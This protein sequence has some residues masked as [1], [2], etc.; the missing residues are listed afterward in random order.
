MPIR[1][2]FDLPTAVVLQLLKLMA[3]TDDNIDPNTL[4][5]FTD[6]GDSIFKQALNG[7]ELAWMQ[8]PP[9]LIEHDMGFAYSYPY[10]S[11]ALRLF[12]RLRRVHGTRFREDERIVSP[13]Q[14]IHK[15][16][17]E[18]GR[19][20]YSAWTNQLYFSA[21]DNTD[22]RVNGRQYFFE[23]PAFLIQHERIASIDE[24]AQASPDDDGLAP[25]N[26]AE[27]S[28]G[29]LVATCQMAWLRLP[30]DCIEQ[31]NGHS[32]YYK[33]RSGAFKLLANLVR[34][35]G[36]KFREDDKLLEPVQAIH[37]QIREVG[38]GAYS[39]WSEQIY[40]S[41][42]DNSDPRRNGRSYYIEVPT[43]IHF[44]ESMPKAGIE[45]FML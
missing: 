13:R 6:R 33:Y 17:R 10:Q 29:G 21:T 34:E 37:S 2:G 7:I 23:V 39:I 4:P 1:S 24:A 43:F 14:A 35:A 8:L 20:A 9:V 30:L 27:I 11:D 19:G 36:L 42:S 38:R 44:I 32:F 26:P 40:F 18:R 41:S 31:E 12:S 5:L 28:L 3:Q 45:R 15:E 22:P 25:N 16:I